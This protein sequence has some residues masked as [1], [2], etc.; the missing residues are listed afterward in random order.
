MDC[1]D[2]CHGNRN[3]VDDGYVAYF[4]KGEW[5]WF[6]GF[7]G[8][9]LQLCWLDRKEVSYWLRCPEERKESYLARF[10][11]KVIDLSIGSDTDFDPGFEKLY[12]AIHEYCS[13]TVDEGKARQTA[14]MSISVQN[15]LWTVFLND[16]A[17]NASLCVSCPTWN[18][19]MTILEEAL[20]SD[21]PAWRLRQENG[22]M[23]R[24]KR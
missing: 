9:N 17:S 18:G 6:F 8:R 5:V 7:V 3:T 24:K 1:N 12:P 4:D 2:G 10:I 11:K 15:G 19:L 16:R 21:C 23:T 22:G 14:T 20:N 13:L